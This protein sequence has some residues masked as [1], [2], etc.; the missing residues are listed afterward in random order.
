MKLAVGRAGAAIEISVQSSFVETAD[1]TPVEARSTLNM[2]G[3]PLTGHAVFTDTGID[4][5]VRQGDGTPST[6][7][8]PLP[9]PGWL[10]PAALERYVAGRLDRR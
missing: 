3:T 1:G 5:T 2:G 7:T 10:P 6:V 8:K 9:A 4:Y